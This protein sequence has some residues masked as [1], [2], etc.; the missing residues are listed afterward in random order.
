MTIPASQ[1]FLYA[2]DAGD[3]NYALKIQ[4]DFNL[5]VGNVIGS[6]SN[7]WTATAS[8]KFMLIAVGSAANNAMFYNPCG[9]SGYSQGSTPFDHNDTPQSSLPGVNH[10]MNA[11]GA[12]GT[13]SYNLAYAYVNCALNDI[14]SSSVSPVQPE[15]VCGGRNPVNQ[16]AS[17]FGTTCDGSDTCSGTV[18]T[19]CPSVDTIQSTAMA[20]GWDPEAIAQS[21]LNLISGS[22]VNTSGMDKYMAVA[23]MSEQGC[24]V[25][26]TTCYQFDSGFTC[27]CSNPVDQ[28]GYGVL[29]DTW[30]SSAGRLDHSDAAMNQVTANGLSTK[31][32]FP[33][34]I[35]P[36]TVVADPGTAFAVFYWWAFSVPYD[37][38]GTIP[39]WVV[40]PCNAAC[41]A[42][43]QYAAKTGASCTYDNPKVGCSCSS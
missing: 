18:A 34:D 7:A 43:Q 33:F 1:V 30:V 10:Y 5:P 36:C 20:S 22:G 19:G 21:V 17:S 40:S 27:N 26:P 12:T 24:Y 16:N 32:W 42:M 28:E 35:T 31:V 15:N 3:Y 25:C 4:T 38:C 37:S 39:Y 13:D 11:A 2:A 29:Q 23:A 41:C 14:C 6:F 9:F 8:G